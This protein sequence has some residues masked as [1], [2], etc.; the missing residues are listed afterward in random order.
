MSET[1]AQGDKKGSMNG[2]R[3][4]DK[5]CRSPGRNSAEFVEACDESE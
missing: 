2:F 3:C 4:G 1:V 5:G